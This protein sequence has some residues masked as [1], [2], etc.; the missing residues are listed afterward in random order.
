M[1]LS[2]LKNLDPKYYKYIER[3]LN[4]EEVDD[5]LFVNNIYANDIWRGS[6]HG[7]K[8][9]L[10]VMKKADKLITMVEKLGVRYPI[11]TKKVLKDKKELYLA[12]FAASY[13]HDISSAIDRKQHGYGGAFISQRYLLDAFEGLPR[14][15]RFVHAISNFIFEHSPKSRTRCSSVGSSIVFIADKLDVSGE[16]LLGQNKADFKD[17]VTLEVR[18]IT[19]E[20]GRRRI[21]ININLNSKVGMYRVENIYS[22]IDNHCPLLKKYIVINA[23]FQGEKIHSS[24][25]T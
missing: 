11:I 19:L 14:R 18:N 10:D 15:G 22:Y 24:K 9:S 6:P 20:Y 13:L 2:T 3:L 8:H 21:H 17:F 25:F 4:N 23:F 5:L 16:R 12:V 7:K 1:E